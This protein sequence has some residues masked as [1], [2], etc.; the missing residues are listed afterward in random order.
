MARINNLTNFLKDLANSI[1]NKTGKSNNIRPEDFDKE[2]ESIEVGIDTSDATATADDILSSKTAYVNNEKIE[3]NIQTINEMYLKT[4][5]GYMGCSNIVACDIS[6][7]GKYVVHSN[8]TN[9]TI[10][11]I[12]EPSILLQFDINRYITSLRFSKKP[13]KL[14]DGDL[15]T[16][17]GGSCGHDSDFA[18]LYAYRILFKKDGTVVKYSDSNYK[19]IVS[20]NLRNYW[21]GN[22]TSVHPHPT[23]HDIII[24]MSST[25]QYAHD[26]RVLR[27]KGTT[28][29]Y[30]TTN[31]YETKGDYGLGTQ[32]Y[33]YT[34]VH[35]VDDNTFSLQDTGLNNYYLTTVDYGNK[36]TISPVE[37]NTIF[38][39][40][41]K[42]MTKNYLIC[43]NRLYRRT[44]E[45]IKSLDGIGSYPLMIEKENNLFIIS[46]FSNTLIYHIYSIE[47]K[48]LENKGKICDINYNSPF[49]N[50]GTFKNYRLDYI[51]NTYGDYGYYTYVEAIDRISEATIKGNRLLNTN[52]TNAIEEDI[53]EGKTAYSNG[54]KLIGTLK[55]AETLN[56]N[57]SRWWST[58]A[59]MLIDVYPTEK[60]ICDQ[61]T[62]MSVN[63]TVDK[64]VEMFR[65]TAGQIAKGQRVLGIDGTYTSDATATADD[66]LEGKIAYVNGEKIIGTCIPSVAVKLPNRIRFENSSC[67]DMDW[68]E[69]T[70]TSNLTTAESMFANNTNLNRAPNMETEKIE[71]FK[72]MFYDCIQLVDIPEYNAD[73][74]IDITNFIHG[75]MIN[76]SNF[77]GLK[78]LGKAY[79]KQIENNSNY[80]L[81]LSS[82]INLTH[83]SL[84]NVI[85]NL[86]D[87]NTNQNLSIDG[88]CEYRQLIRLGKTNADK[89]S[90]EEIEIILNKGWNIDPDEYG[91]RI[92]RILNQVDNIESEYEGYGSNLNELDGLLDSITNGSV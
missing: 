49:N 58:A 47:N 25:R 72:N 63:V 35:W 75:E 48:T 23:R 85:N 43:D 65:L 78:N 70:D 54:E 9:A 42:Y 28:L 88:V 67:A 71:N 10:N 73:N 17:Y 15:Y 68:I 27:D 20:D 59:S 38:G 52:D 4:V 57:A 55:Y 5:N 56:V 60:A 29:E 81:D 53:Y 8:G 41:F 84:I 69:N 86:Y 24:L 22:Y 64:I 92:M 16:V 34:Y 30:S 32:G 13:I 11:K 45:F 89:L 1:R 90:D 79:T 7:D 21:E 39:S 76:L 19:D 26:V 62:Y 37:K 44:G 91:L 2:I 50:T 12:G 77:G 31:R 33:D 87:L 3:G 61:N 40:G 36:L 66:I 14:E 6:P 74:V 82:A 83:E 46:M 18:Y 51:Q 80:T